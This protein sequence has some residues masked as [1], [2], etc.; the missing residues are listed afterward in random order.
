M[1]AWTDGVPPE[2]LGQDKAL[3]VV[4]LPSRFSGVNVVSYRCISWLGESWSDK[5]VFRARR[6]MLIPY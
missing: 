1:L 6:W 3:I 5:E 4:E 2:F